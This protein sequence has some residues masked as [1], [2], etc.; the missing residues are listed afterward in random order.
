MAE[1]DFGDAGDAIG[2][3]PVCLTAQGV[4]KEKHDDVH[5]LL[6][7]DASIFTEAEI[8]SDDDAGAPPPPPPPPPPSSSG[9]QG[10][11]AAF[12]AVIVAVAAAGVVTNGTFSFAW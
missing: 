3:R 10:C 7:D 12:V 9:S 1:S 8:D 2:R 6:H 5:R 11:Q 4:P